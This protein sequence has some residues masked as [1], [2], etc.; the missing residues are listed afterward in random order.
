MAATSN[1]SQNDIGNYLCLHV[2]WKLLALS[3]YLQRRCFWGM[4]V[5]KNQ[6][7]S[8]APLAV[9]L[10]LQ[11]HPHRAPPIYRNSRMVEAEA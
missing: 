4:E 3:N 10:L 9:G 2:A 11:G 1:T 7:L 8:D 5:S 6:G